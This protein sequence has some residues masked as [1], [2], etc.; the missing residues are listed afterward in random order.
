MSGLVLYLSLLSGSWPLKFLILFYQSQETSKNSACFY[1]FQKQ[2]FVW[3]KAWVDAQ[4]L[5]LCPELAMPPGKEGQQNICSLLSFL[6]SGILASVILVALLALIPLNSQKIL[7]G[8]LG[9]YIFKDEVFFQKNTFIDFR[10]ER[11]K[12]Q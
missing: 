6:I 3:R 9:I 2:P 5:D 1:V 7:S 11:E 12:H 4:P 8:F 10:G